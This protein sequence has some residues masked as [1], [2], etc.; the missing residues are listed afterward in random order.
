MAEK[1]GK[2]KGKVPA[3]VKEFYDTVPPTAIVTGKQI[4]LA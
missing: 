2:I 1:K 3:A 4:H